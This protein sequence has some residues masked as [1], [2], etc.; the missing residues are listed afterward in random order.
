MVPAESALLSM[1]P[2]MLI[3]SPILSSMPTVSSILTESPTTPT[4]PRLTLT[5]LLQGPRCVSKRAKAKK[6]TLFS[7]NSSG[8]SHYENEDP[9]SL[10]KPKSKLKIAWSNENITQTHL[11]TSKHR[12][13][14]RGVCIEKD[15]QLSRQLKTENISCELRVDESS[16]ALAIS[17]G[18]IWNDNC[19]GSS[20]TPP[21][22]PHLNS[23]PKIPYP[24]AFVHNSSSHTRSIPSLL[25]QSAI[26]T[27]IHSRRPNTTDGRLHTAVSG[28]FETLVYRGAPSLGTPIEQENL[29]TRTLPDMGQFRSGPIGGPRL[30]TRSTIENSPAQLDK[31]IS[32]A[33]QFAPI[34]DELSATI[35]K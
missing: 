27:H 31:R 25:S 29:P 2:C 5:D 12:I 21:P 10:A 24:Q 28:L 4:T 15:P 3:E 20:A 11:P 33:K 32:F 19:N 17:S 34:E 14:P 8:S 23:Q 26:E 35:F 1:E 9:S 16:L 7:V 13:D 6:L 18:A 22:E 30:E